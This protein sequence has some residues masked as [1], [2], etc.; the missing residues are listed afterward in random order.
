MKKQT[1]SDNNLLKPFI[2][3]AGGKNQL[4]PDIQIKYPQE[5]GKTI[6]KYCEPF[7]GGGAVLFDILSNYKIEKILI[8]DINKEL[9][10]VY[11]QIKSN[12]STLILELQKIQKKYWAM[13]IENQKKFYIK[14]RN[15]F[16]Y[17]K[18]NG[19]KKVNIEKAVLFIFLN[20]TC[21]NGLF[22]VNS[23]GLFNV[24]KGSYKK[25]LICDTDNLKAI[26][27]KIKNIKITCGDYEQCLSFIDKNTF[28][29]I[30][31]PYRPLSQT[32]SFTSYSEKIFDDNEQYRLGRFIDKINKI[33]AKI[34]LSNSDPT[35]TN[36]NDKFFDDMYKNYNIERIL[37][38]RFINCDA[39]KRS[40]VREL[41]ITN[42]K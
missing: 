27:K 6:N 24:P 42:Y 20:K 33:K 14:K 30:D 3:W 17:L 7:V 10:N 13:D 39:T 23:K 4:L 11:K 21:F 38:K 36:K 9:I 31:P 22:R 37:A 25:P 19:N 34:I 16:N 1:Y 28:V 35:N 5:L 15:R 40:D 18:V 8:N 2:K 12:V 29:Y 26:S 32:A 41:L